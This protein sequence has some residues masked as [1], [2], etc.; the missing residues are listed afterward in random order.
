MIWQK[1]KKE[2]WEIRRLQWKTEKN[3]NETSVNAVLLPKENNESDIL[4]IHIK[5]EVDNEKDTYT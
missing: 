5:I 3:K 4:K 1:M 2:N